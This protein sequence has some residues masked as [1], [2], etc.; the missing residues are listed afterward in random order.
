MRAAQGDITLLNAASAGIL[1]GCRGDTTVCRADSSIG[2]QPGQR[3][4]GS[5]SAAGLFGIGRKQ[6]RR[7]RALTRADPLDELVGT[8]QRTERVEALFEQLL[9]IG[10]ARPRAPVRASGADRCETAA[11]A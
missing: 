2:F 10:Q 11:G 5:A 1:C 6:R 3:T 9:Q 4:I 7:E 8:L